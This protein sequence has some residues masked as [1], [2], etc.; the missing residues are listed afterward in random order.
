M[1]CSALESKFPK[2]GIKVPRS[3][4]EVVVLSREAAGSLNESTTHV[5]AA[6]VGILVLVLVLWEFASGRFVDPFIAS[7]P[8]QIAHEF[9]RGLS[10]GTILS[11][12]A[13]TLSE[14]A[15]GFL[16][17]GILA[18]ILGYAAGVSP[19]WAQVLAPY[20]GSLFSVPRIAFVPILIIWLGVGKPLAV[21]VS[22]ILTFFLLFYN[23]YY[24]I[25]EVSVNLLDGMRIMGGSRWDLAFRVRLPSAFV[26][27]V[28]GL[29]T[30]IPQALVGAVT[31]EILASNQGLGYLI[32]FNAAQFNTAAAFAGLVTL[33]II[34]L[35]LYECLETISSRALLWKGSPK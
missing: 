8:S 6:R 1:I 12:T 33:A 18:L 32:Q 16:A 2:K 35:I 11:A 7:S 27:I 22:A 26:W 34:G 30:S 14:A 31:A 25:R 5:W 10:N 15:L 13:T 24:G 19:F 17:G 20:I 4:A 21:V 3:R 23:T 29:K 9:F 28:A